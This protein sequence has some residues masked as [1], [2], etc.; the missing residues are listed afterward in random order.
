MNI[1]DYIDNLPAEPFLSTPELWGHLLD[2][3]QSTYRGFT[4]IESQK[5]FLR[6]EASL[7]TSN[8]QEMV[9]IL[10]FRVLEEIGESFDSVDPDH[11]KE[12]AVDAV[13]YLL[14]IPALDPRSLNRDRLIP[15]LMTAVQT[16]TWDRPYD[17]KQIG[18]TVLLFS[19]IGDTLR[20]RAWMENA[21]DTYFSGA[22]YLQDVIGLVMSQLMGVCSNFDEFCRIYIAKDEVL[23]FR[24][25]SK[26]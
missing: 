14:A 2:R 13:N 11:V 5:G 19:R 20:N 10:L 26:Y 1:R 16:A 21:Q 12:E 4:S 9:R 22:L 8:G 15:V 18:E 6:P 7:N 25:R 3:R 17:H 23:N 24:L